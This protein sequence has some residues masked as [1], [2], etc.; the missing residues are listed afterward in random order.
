MSPLATATANPAPPWA[1][2]PEELVA[3]AKELCRAH[4]A[5]LLFLTLFGATLYGTELPGKSDL[6]VRGVFLPG[7]AALAK[8]KG[9]RGL[10]FSTGQ[11]P[12]KNAAHDVDLDLC[13]VQQWLLRLLPA[14]DIGGLDLLFA[15]S[16]AACVLYQ[17]PCLNAV[18][19][20]P[21]RLI[22]VPGSRGY[23]EYALKQAKKYGIKGSRAGALKLTQ[24]W[25]KAHCPHPGPQ[26]RLGHYLP[27]LVAACADPVHCAL[28]QLPDEQYLQ[29]GGKLHAA[30]TPMPEFVRRVDAH[31]KPLAA[32][33]AAAEK[34]QGL[35]FKALSHALRALGQ[36]RE[37]LGE[38]RIVFP[39][40]NRAEI[41]AIKNGAYTWAELESMI[42]AEIA[43]VDALRLRAVLPESYDPAFA[44]ACVAACYK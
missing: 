1:P 9:L 8:G 14:G 25:L 10:H 5:R 43:A 35:D 41:M 13:P 23:A 24:A 2:R 36:M 26:E 37:L 39:L 31:L 19:A 34:N 42:L 4:D 30:S 28:K 44:R 40:R 18:F 16:H 29:L 7:P 22:N 33:L 20:A 32:R 6:D 12:A 15:P 3:Q 38:G 17:D 11:G 27:A 21:L